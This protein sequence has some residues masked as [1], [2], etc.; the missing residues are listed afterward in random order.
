MVNR[1]FVLVGFVYVASFVSGEILVNL[2]FEGDMVGQQPEIADV[3][4]SPSS[5]NATNGAKVINASSDPVNPLSGNSLYV[6][7]L[8]GDLVNGDNT[9]LR[10]PFNGGTNRTDVR[11]SFDFQR[12]SASDPLDTDTRVHVALGRVGNSLNNSDFRPF[13]LRIHNNGDLILNSLAGSATVAS[14]LTNAVNHV[15][16]LTNSH[17]TNTVNYDLDGLVT[18][19]VLPNTLHLFLNQSKLGE[20]DY[21]VTPDPANA[22]QVI[23]NQQDDDL[24][25]F[26]IYQDSKRQGEMVFDNILISPLNEVFGPPASPESLSLT[27]TTP[28]SVELAWMD[29]S[30]DEI[31]FII[32]R[33]TGSEGSFES[34]AT[35]TSNV[36][37]YVDDSVEPETDYTYRI[38]ADNSFKSDPSNELPVT[39]PEQI[40]PLI[41]D[42]AVDSFVL[43]GNTASLSVTAVGRDPLTYQWYIGDTGDTSQPINKANLAAYQSEALS[44]DTSFWVRA[45]NNDG[46]VDSQ[47]FA[48]TVREGV[49][50]T[51]ASRSEIESALATALPGDTLIVSNGTYQD[52]VIELEGNGKENAPITLRA[53]TPGQ[54]IL[55]G[56]SRAQIGGTWLVMDGLVLE[57]HYTG[58]DDDIIQFRS[59]GAI[60]VDCRL[61]NTSVIDYVPEDGQKTSYVAMYG[62]RNRVDHCYFSGHDVIGVT[63]VVWLDGQPNNHLID[64]NHFANRID[65]GGENGWET[66]RIGTSDR[67]LSDSRTIVE[68]NLF[69][70]L[71]GEIEIISNKSGEN[72]YRYNTFLESR[73]TLTLRHGNRCLVE[74]NYFIGG[75]RSGT[76]GVRVIGEDH[77]VINNYFESTTARAGAAI[78]LYAGVSGGALNEYVEADNAV[79]AFNT[80]YDNN[81][82]YIGVGTGFGARDR[83][84][85]PT[86]IKVANNLLIAESKTV[87]DF[88]NGENP[89]DQTWDG[90]LIFGRSMG[91]GLIDGFTVV[92]PL[93]ELDP[94]AG[95][96]RIGSASPAINAASDL[97]D[98]V[99]LDID[100]QTRVAVPDVGADERSDQSG[101]ANGPLAAKDVGP[102]YQ[103]ALRPLNTTLTIPFG[104]DGWPQLLS[105]TGAFSEFLR[106][107][108]NEGILTYEPN[109]SFWSDY[110]KKSRW[111]YI[112][113][114]ST[115]GYSENS[116]WQF[117]EGSVWIKHFDMELRRGDPSQAFRIETRFLVKTAFSIYG[118]SYRWNE[119]G[120]EATLVGEDGV[121]FELSLFD[122]ANPITQTWSIPS[123]SD[124]LVCHTFTGGEALSFNTRQL[125]RT[126]E[127]DGLEQNL[128]QYLSDHAF[129]NEKLEDA[130]ALPYFAHPDD[131][132]AS[133]DFKA[134]S[135]LAVNCSYCHQPGGTESDSFDVRA[136]RMLE[137]TNLIDDEPSINNGDDTLKVV[138]RGNADKSTFYLRMIADQGLTRMPPIAT[139]EID[140]VGSE[141]I[142][143]WINNGLV[144]LQFY[145]E[146]Q[147]AIFGEDA[148]TKG[149][150]GNDADFD[151]DSN[152]TEFLNQT[153]PLSGVE[154]SRV[155][156]SRQD[157]STKINFKGGPFTDYQ[158]ETSVDLDSWRPASGDA[159]RV[160]TI[161][162]GSDSVE[163]ILQP[164]DISA[165]N[166]FFRVTAKQR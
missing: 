125:N 30:D 122:G 3:N 164:E 43:V 40:V 145:S 138:L 146:W 107:T 36:I 155:N 117:P 156:V 115:I 31:G 162:E 120:T 13:E 97:F 101:L 94:V 124:C 82:P 65:G 44:D 15:D 57:G 49:E 121:S 151:G 129:L 14:Y 152:G 158:V 19:M 144:N 139:N 70:R 100:G 75:F 136:H 105:E 6:Y 106:L 86:G 9:H 64:N 154:I 76:G 56:E 119:E 42:S 134:R 89:E 123:R 51:V 166:Q 45:M 112:P 18:G 23:F 93:L 141:L 35:V 111:F 52:L 127:I 46:Q 159:G 62:Q 85:R 67:S 157:G 25:Q 161:P 130:H 118:V 34:I 153:D 116:N 147:E 21:H 92:D 48:V 98:E 10:F 142:K 137:F 12:A 53:E 1:V 133:L 80:F 5:N 91:G 74:G 17:D 8:N 20:Y 108:P 90:N 160:L 165:L 4:I 83:T 55:Q 26:A 135:Y 22:P 24:G 95:I 149:A 132:D 66:I 148:N 84:V 128:L 96:Q 81:G 140:P 58:N 163:L 27:S 79:V 72:I 110:A 60:A 29:V 63:L 77:V 7:D 33:R 87:G 11:L 37:T 131:P 68:H 88:V 54:V 78:T 47:T 113:P 28:F 50:F 38:I 61:T 71:D 73:G 99:D 39:T 126:Q 114:G 103:P 69:S 109:L 102:N 16:V 59:G 2:D 150:I 104:E 32:E 41:L 143:D